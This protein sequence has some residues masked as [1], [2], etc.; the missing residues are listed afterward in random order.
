MKTAIGLFERREDA[1]RALAR[2]QEGG[3]AREQA[4]ILD[5]PDAVRRRMDCS[6]KRNVIKDAAIGAA[7]IGGI[8]AVFGLFAGLCDSAIGVPSGWCIGATVVFI[9]IGAGLGAFGGAFIG[10]AEAEKET[11]LYLEGVRRGN[12]LMLIRT[13]DDGAAQALRMMRQ[14]HAL[15]VRICSRARPP[16]EISS[17]AH[18]HSI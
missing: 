3:L 2:L 11:H 16:G 18:P 4:S 12:L 1:E 15:G 9:V 5:T 10:R 6:Y 7:L 14:E 13:D 17:T 8:Y